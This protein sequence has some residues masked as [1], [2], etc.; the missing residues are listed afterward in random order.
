MEWRGGEGSGG[1]GVESGG[2]EVESGGEGKV[3]DGKGMG[4]DEK[5]GE[6]I[7]GV[8]KKRRGREQLSKS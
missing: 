2:E 3:G 6:G 7:G 4:T 1:E 5:K 8:K